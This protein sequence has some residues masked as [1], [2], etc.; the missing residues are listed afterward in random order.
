M[1]GNTI[2]T[3]LRPTGASLGSVAAFVSQFEPFTT[4]EFGPMMKSLMYQL[5]HGTHAVTMI[6]DPM[7]GK[8]DQ[9][10]AYVGWI[11]TS[12]EIAEDWLER[13]GRLSLSSDDDGA[14][15]VT[16]LAAQNPS[17][18]LGLIKHAKRINV[19]KS[20]YWKRYFTDGREPMHRS[21]VKKQTADS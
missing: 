8:V 21:V 11:K 16:I 6:G 14:I 18:I 7:T 17:G 4:Y 10:A 1:S 20:V 12:K 13:D 2:Y 9:M 19:G 3:T 15:A 5:E